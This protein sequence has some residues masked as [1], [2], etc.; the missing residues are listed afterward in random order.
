MRKLYPLLAAFGLVGLT[1]GCDDSPKPKP[2]AEPKV[3]LGAPGTPKSD[4]AKPPAAAPTT[5]PKSDADK[6]K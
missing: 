2:P 3:E 4:G 1:V 5:A 6:P